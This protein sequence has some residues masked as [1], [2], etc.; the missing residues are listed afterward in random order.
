VVPTS[1]A[2]RC[3]RRYYGSPVACPR[4]CQ[5]VQRRCAAAAAVA[6]MSN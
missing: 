2:L 1:L 5:H 3:S 6:P 4:S